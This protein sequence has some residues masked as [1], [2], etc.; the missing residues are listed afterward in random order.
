MRLATANLS[1]N[2]V[3]RRILIS[4]AAMRYLFNGAVKFNK[5]AMGG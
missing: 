3:S 5:F 2:I 1:A 4:N